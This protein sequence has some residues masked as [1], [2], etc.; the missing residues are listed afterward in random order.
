[1]EVPG[2]ECVHIHEIP[3]EGFDKTHITFENGRTIKATNARKH[4]TNQKNPQ[5]TRRRGSRCL[6]GS[7]KG[8]SLTGDELSPW[9]DKIMHVKL[10]NGMISVFDWSI[11]CQW[12]N[13]QPDPEP[14]LIP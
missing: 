13:S 10:E 12:D 8:P 3:H 1:M 4:Q 5:R 9:S 11:S 14:R 6:D 7:W 2:T